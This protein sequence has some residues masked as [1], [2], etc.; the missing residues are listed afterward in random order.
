MP[1]RIFLKFIFLI[2]FLGLQSC[3]NTPSRSCS[4]NWQI[5]GYFTPVE[6]NHH[7]KKISI[8]VKNEKQFPFAKTFLD[9]VKIEGWGK[10]RFGWYL[11]Y[12]SQQWHKSKWPLDSTGRQLIHGIAATDPHFIAKGSSIKIKSDISY[13]GNTT[14]IARD[15]GSKIKNRH[16][17]IYT[18]EGKS[19]KKRTFEITGKHSICVHRPD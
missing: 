9:A 1:Q 7:G 18:G 16:I 12:Y 5:T 2:S 15:V 8:K 13:L 14:F 3:V 17:D 4:D 19:A 10:T 11:G 6:N